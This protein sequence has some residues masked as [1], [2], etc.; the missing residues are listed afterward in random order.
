VLLVR[1]FEAEEELPLKVVLDVSKSMEFYGKTEIGKVLAGMIAYLG[2][3]GGDRIQLFAVGGAGSRS[4][5]AGPVGRHLARWPQLESWIEQLAPGGGGE[6]APALRQ[7][8]GEG[9]TRG[10]LVLVSDLLSPDF[11]KALD[12]LG[13]GSGGIVLHVLGQE[14]LDPSLAGDL[15]LADSESGGEVEVSTSEDA[16]RRYRQAL[17][18]FATEAAARARRAGLDY[19]LVPATTDAPMQVLGALARTEALR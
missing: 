4:L 17:E 5:Q 3:A 10:A 11:G 2:L 18:S 1:Q 12:G 19:V 16:M 15:R 14:E 7:L 6:L 13:V 9:T 8:V